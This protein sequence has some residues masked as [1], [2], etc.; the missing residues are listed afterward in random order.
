MDKLSMKIQSFSLVET[1]IAVNI[2]MI[3]FFIVMTVLG[4]IMVN[5]NVNHKIE[6]LTQIKSLRHQATENQN[7]EDKEIK[8]NTMKITQK[9]KEYGNT[10]KL[11]QLQHEATNNTK[12]TILKTNIIERKKVN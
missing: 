9:T 2:I 11:I 8:H 1:I 7:Y 10:G 6:A 12:K 4:N 5:G 3:T